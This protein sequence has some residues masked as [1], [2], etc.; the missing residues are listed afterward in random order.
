MFTFSRF[1]IKTIA[2]RWSIQSFTELS[3]EIISIVSQVAWLH[4][5]GLPQTIWVVILTCGLKSIMQVIDW[6]PNKS[7]EPAPVGAFSS[8]ARFTVFGPAWLSFFR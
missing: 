7:P 3:R 5:A 1:T 8:A 6:Q 4:F 2:G